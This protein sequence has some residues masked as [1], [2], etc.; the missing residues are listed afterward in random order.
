MEK[1]ENSFFEY[2]DETGVGSDSESEFI[3]NSLMDES[4]APKKTP[5]KKNQTAFIPESDDSITGG[6]VT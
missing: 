5:G 6:I 3:D 1:L 4:I 2:R